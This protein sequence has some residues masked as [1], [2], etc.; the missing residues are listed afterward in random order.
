MKV[1]YQGDEVETSQAT[2]AGFLQER[3][4][5]AAKAIVEYAGEVYVPGAD[6]T[7]LTLVPGTT[8]DVF[9]L[10]AGG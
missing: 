4:V 7:Q 2:V 5:D 3:Q 6:L 9:R 10:T 8:L 1:V